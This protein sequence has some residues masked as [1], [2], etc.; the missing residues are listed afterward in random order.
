MKNTACVKS[1]PAS[2]NRRRWNSQ[3]VAPWLFLLPAVTLV[4]CFV[5]LP[6][7]ISLILSFFKYDGITTPVFTGLKHYKIL[8]TNENFYISLKNTLIFVIASNIP[9]LILAL[10]LALALNAKWL[11]GSSALRAIFFMP[12]VVSTV[13][14]S[15]VWMFILSPEFGTINPILE[16]FGIGKQY[17]L[18]DPKQA[19]AII[20]IIA[21]WRSLGYSMVIYLAGL[22]GIDQS[23]YEVS[24]LEGANGFETLRYVT[25]PLLKPT[26][27][28]ILSTGVINGFQL[29]DFPQVLTNGGPGSATST[30]VMHIYLKAF[31]EM[32]QGYAS[33]VSFVLF[34]IILIVTMLMNKYMEDESV[35]A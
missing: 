4:F 17:F 35:N 11:K 16:K 18:G 21:V 2:I 32:N 5:L 22:Q 26:T 3:K 20:V 23:Y 24:K 15:F 29:F 19:L 31:Q 13:A 8:F 25:L 10:L 28:F 14:V 1:V 6:T 33:A 30:I 9:N 12:S 7:A 34:I 27:F